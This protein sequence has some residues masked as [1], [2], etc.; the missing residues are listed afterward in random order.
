[1]TLD[2][3]KKSNEEL[4]D[5]AS[6]ANTIINNRLTAGFKAV[7]ER[8]KRGDAFLDDELVYAAHAR[9]KCGA[10]VAY[11]KGIGPGG[12]FAG[13]FCSQ[14]LTGRNR[15]MDNHEGMLPFAFY[16]IKSEDQPSAN[17]VTTRP[18]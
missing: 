1:M 13:W 11:A 7:E 15:D 4:R 9:C 5:I 12:E 2:L 18:K 8:F 14:V 16:Q 10:G 17:G 3:E 6:A